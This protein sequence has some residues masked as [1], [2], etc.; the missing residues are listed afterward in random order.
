MDPDIQHYTRYNS[1]EGEYKTIPHWIVILGLSNL[2]FFLIS[3]LFFIPKPQKNIFT[4]PWFAHIK[5]NNVFLLIII[6]VVLVHLLEVSFIDRYTTQLVQYDFTEHIAAFESEVVYTISNEAQPALA[7]FFVCMY[8][9]VYP[10]TLWF[11]PF[12]FLLT[13]E[14]KALKLF[15][16]GLLVMYLCALP[17]YLFLPITNVYTYYHNTSLLNETIP[18]V[19]QFL[20]ATTTT[21]NCFPSLH[22]AMTI[23][24]AV[25]MMFTKNL[26]LKYTTTVCAIL[27]VLSVIYLGIHWLTDV[28]GGILLVS[29]VVYLLKRTI[30]GERHG[31]TT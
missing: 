14:Y 3:I 20:Y 10:F 26:R 9:I 17:F 29:I 19:E 22:T 1:Q 2:L 11:T 15:S 7:S 23:L 5:K 8:I 12:Y 16:Y 4:I 13:D 27:V 21:N 31:N 28:L 24:I 6:G 18:G 25:S 30:I